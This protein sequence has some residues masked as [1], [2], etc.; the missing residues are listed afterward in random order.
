MDWIVCISYYTCWVFYEI[1]ITK[2]LHDVFLVHCT[3]A[4]EFWFRPRFRP[5]KKLESTVFSV[6]SGTTSIYP[7]TI[8]R[9]VFASSPPKLKLSWLECHVSL[10]ED[11]S[12]HQI[13][14]SKV[15]VHLVMRADCL[16]RG[17]VSPTYHHR[18]CPVGVF[19]LLKYY[20]ESWW[21]LPWSV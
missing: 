13:K 14:R 11:L 8:K 2:R 19:A 1:L 9:G 3:G 10:H 4:W 6:V 20:T 15:Y 18:G 17:G 16:A 7:W 12:H 5:S 21:L